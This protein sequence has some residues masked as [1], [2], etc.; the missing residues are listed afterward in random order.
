V[1]FSSKLAIYS[2]KIGDFIEKCIFYWNG[3]FL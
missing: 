2:I 1:N 3:W